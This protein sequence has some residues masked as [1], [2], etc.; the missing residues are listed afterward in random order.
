MG[1]FLVIDF[2]LQTYL[3][4]I[5]YLVEQKIQHGIILSDLSY[6]DIIK[7]HNLIICKSLINQI[8]QHYNN[9]NNPKTDYWKPTWVTTSPSPFPFPQK[10]CSFPYQS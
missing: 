4:F 7:I 2:W 10:V 6:L 5:K 3:L 8:K 1:E 9:N